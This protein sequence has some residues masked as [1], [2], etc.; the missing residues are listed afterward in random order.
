MVFL[1]VILDTLRQAGIALLPPMAP[2]Q[3][4]EIRDH[5]RATPAYTEH[6]QA[7]SDGAARNFDHTAEGTEIWCHAMSDVVAAPH[8]FEFALAQVELARAYLEALPRLYSMNAFW[9]RPGTRAPVAHLQ[10]WHRD[11]DDDR[12]LAFFVYGTDV[13]EEA[14]GPHEYQLGTHH[15]GEPGGPIS[16]FGP[17]GTAWAADTHGLHRGPKPA[18][19]HRLLLWARYGVSD[20]PR[21]YLQ[22]RLESVPA[23]V[24][25]DRYPSDPELREIVRLVVQ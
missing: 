7:Y 12:F 3:I 23:G 10:E 9:T 20:P 21:A 24:L 4:A 13:E 14:D 11:N 1:S 19:G 22:D 8:F 15:G 16:V 5:L 17:A 25:G 6:V 18:R 2:E